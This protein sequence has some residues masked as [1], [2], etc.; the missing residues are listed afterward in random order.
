MTTHCITSRN[1]FI[2]E[3]TSSTGKKKSIRY[4][5]S[6]L[7]SEIKAEEQYIVFDEQPATNVVIT[8]FKKQDGE[9]VYQNGKP[10]TMETKAVLPLRFGFGSY[11]E[12]MKVLNY[13]IDVQDI[14]LI[15]AEE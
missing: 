10:I 1:P 14:V 6:L 11:N 13:G 15:S 8:H 9:T 3:Y 4:A 12:P 2:V 7:E 5:V